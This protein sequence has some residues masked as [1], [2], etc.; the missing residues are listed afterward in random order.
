MHVESEVVRRSVHHVAAMVLLIG[1]ERLLGAHRQKPPLGGALRDDRHRGGVDL[2]EPDARPHDRE[3]RV[4]RIQNRLIDP[5][6]HVAE[7]AIHGQRACDVGGV[8]AL[9]LDARVEQYELAG[10]DRTV[11][12]HP[13]K[14][15]GVRSG[16]RDRVVAD[17]VALGARPTVE[18]ALDEALAT[19]MRHDRLEIGDDILES[20][21]GRRDRAP[22]LLDLEGVLDQAQFAEVA[23]EIGIRLGEAVPVR[24]KDRVAHRVGGG[25]R[26]AAQIDCRRDLAIHITHLQGFRLELA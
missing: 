26:N 1:L 23:Q 7:P 3:R 24:G 13:V 22:H 20:G 25:E 15:A 12:A 19:R 14:D 17:R 9:E 11:V 10:H 16:C 6:L 5:A 21:C 8:I 2:A 4:R 18:R